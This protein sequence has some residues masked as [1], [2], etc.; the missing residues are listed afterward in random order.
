MIS[1]S[2][3][4]C[5]HITTM[6]VWEILPEKTL[7]IE[8]IESPQTSTFLDPPLLGFA[9]SICPKQAPLGLPENYHQERNFKKNKIS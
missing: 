3:H 2:G 1:S 7:K 5:S 9:V 6:N 8:L 4:L